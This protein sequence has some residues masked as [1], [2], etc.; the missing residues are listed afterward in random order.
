[1]PSCIAIQSPRSHP[2]KKKNHPHPLPP[3]PPLPPHTPPHP[4][5]L[6]STHTP[7]SSTPST[8]SPPHPMRPLADRQARSGGARALRKVPSRA[9][10]SAADTADTDLTPSRPGHQR[11]RGRGRPRETRGNGGSLGGGGGE[12][13]SFLSTVPSEEEARERLLRSSGGLARHSHLRPTTLSRSCPCG[14][15]VWWWRGHRPPRPAARCTQPSPPR[16]SAGAQTAE[17]LWGRG[18]WRKCGH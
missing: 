5:H 18:K 10:R 12:G 6:L 17:G 16:C 2:Q 4:H 7:S 9:T 13:C 1:M 14:A 11:G 15:T 3:P 8:S